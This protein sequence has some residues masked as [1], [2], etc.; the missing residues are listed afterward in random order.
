MFYKNI[1]NKFTTYLEI[2]SKNPPT[3]K[4]S[5]Y[6]IASFIIIGIGLLIGIGFIYL[7]YLKGYRITGELSNATNVFGTYLGG[8]IAPLFSLAGVFLFYNALKMQSKEL[9]ISQGI[10]IAQKE[11][12]ELTRCVLEGQQGS[13]ERQ[14]NILDKQNFETTF[15]NLLNN[16]INVKN[17]I[18]NNKNNSLLIHQVYS[19]IQAKCKLDFETAP[20]V[21]T[22]FKEAF[23]YWETYFNNLNL[24][25][26]FINKSST[27]DKKFYY[28][29][30]FGQCDSYEKEVILY[31]SVINPEILTLLSIEPEE[32][33]I[34]DTNLINDQ[35][36]TFLNT[37]NFKVKHY[38]DF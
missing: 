10:L 1:Y 14:A 34:V 26:K 23:V 32:S 11:E 28:S 27:I 24:T 13:L 6:V 9:N 29:L 18:K 4:T 19:R 21:I 7:V 30:V 12:L 25:L 36:N 38:L 31:Y 17:G 2:K 37:H 35:L 22:K 8:V 33:F 16:L 20:H 15:F 3:Q 5:I